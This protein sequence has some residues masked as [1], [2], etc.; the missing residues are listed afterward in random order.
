MDSNKCF[1]EVRILVE[2]NVCY[3]QMLELDCAKNN[4]LLGVVFNK[5]NPNN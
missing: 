1:Q 4:I 5:E 2:L 3:E